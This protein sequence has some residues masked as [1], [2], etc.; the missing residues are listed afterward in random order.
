VGSDDDRATLSEEEL[1]REEDAQV[2]A[3][4]VATAVAGGEPGGGDAFAAERALLDRM[5]AVAEA[6]RGEPDARVRRLVAWIREHMCPGL[7]EQGSPGGDAP[8]E[9]NGTRLLIFTEYEDTRRYLYQQ[10]SAAVEGTDRGESRID[11][12]H[13]PTPAARREEIKRAF[14]TDPAKHPLRI[15]IATDAAREGLN[16]QRHCWNLFHFD[17]PW[18][19]GRLEQRNGRIDRKLQPNDAV[20]CHYFVYWQREE[21]RILRA[22]V[23]KTETI[24]AELGSLAQ[25]VD[26]RLVHTLD[27]G[28]RHADVD[29]LEREIE[30]A[31][32]DASARETVEEE[33]EQ[34]RERQ[35]ELLGQIDR[36]RRVLDESRRWIG[37]REDH[38]RAAISSALHVMDAPALEPLGRGGD[39]TPP[40]YAFPALDRRAGADPTWADAMD[41]LRA[42]R[43]RD[44][45]PWEWRRDSPVRPVVFEDTGALGDE[46]VHLH[47]EHRVV[48]RLLGRFTA[49]GFVH[50]DLSRACVAHAADAIPRVVLLG[51]LALYGPG[52]ARLHEEIVP[53]T[54]RWVEPSHRKGPLAPYGRDA[55]GRTLQVLEEALLPRAG[56]AVEPVVADRL[57]ASVPRDMQELLPR[58][59]ERGNAVAED[60]RARLAERGRVEA[61]EMRKILEEQKHRLEQAA[62]ERDTT[63]LSFDLDPEERRQHESERRHWS[64]RLA[65]LDGELEREPERIRALYEV[66]AQ[67]VEP[68]GI[69]YLWPVTG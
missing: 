48:R 23:R 30:D 4:T 41:A 33:L 19:P 54:A 66:R 10:L 5:A 32:L 12:I 37:L 1:G 36:V 45:Q 16:L 31:D 35:E 28:I 25:V 64:K 63:Q 65:E 69:V 67:R 46:A 7:P 15:L 49:Q 27:A 51:R 9:W 17:V 18:N 13:G 59:E 29:R 20:Y 8:A 11:Y 52:A 22:L 53:V 60:A 34:A 14:N 58:L 40:R 61:E 21:D 3:A 55:E 38:F 56:H 26:S 62:R 42:P 39:D 24:K 43:R 2:E 68:V 6:A 50:H 47:L 44:Q 57:R